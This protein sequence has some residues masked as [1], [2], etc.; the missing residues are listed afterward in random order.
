M[1]LLLLQPVTEISRELKELKCDLKSREKSHQ[2]KK[3]IV[4]GAEIIWIPKKH[5]LLTEIYICNYCFI[6]H[7]SHETNQ[8]L[9]HIKKKFEFSLA[10]TTLIFWNF[11]FDSLWL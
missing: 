4:R 3:K 2:S 7:V 10:S 1:L 9:S 11:K 8:N 6:G 5:Y